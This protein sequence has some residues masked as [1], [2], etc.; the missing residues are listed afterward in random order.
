[1][2]SLRFVLAIASLSLAAA[3][4]A[5]DTPATDHH[6]D[7]LSG[8]KANWQQW[9]ALPVQ[10]GGRY[11][12]LDSLCWE[13]GRL[14]SNRISQPDPDTGVRLDAVGFYL[15]L[16]FD[17]QI[18]EKNQGSQSASGGDRL[19]TYFSTREADK[20]DRQPLIV[21]DS[22]ELRQALGMP[23]DKRFIAPWDLGKAKLDTPRTKESS[24]LDWAE[25]LA[26]A[27]SRKLDPFEKEGLQL[28]NRLWAYVEHRSGRRMAIAPV[29][30]NAKEEWLSVHDLLQTK[31]ERPAIERLK[32]Q[33]LKVQAAYRAGDAEAF[34]AASAALIAD[35]V[36][37]GPTLGEYPVQKFINLEVAYNHWAPFRLAWILSLTACLC[38]LLSLGTGLRG[39]YASACLAGVLSLVA[40]LAGFW[41]RVTISG[42]AP[43]TDMY[44]SVVYVGF[45]TALFAL[46][47][48]WL[49]RKQF[50]LAAGMAVAAVAL[51]LA[52]N[53]PAILDPSLRPLQPVLRSNFWLVTHVMTITL[54]YAAFALALGISDITL[55]Y[56]L[57]RP[58]K[59]ETIAALSLFS[60]RA[61]QVGV[62][63]L[64][65]GIVLGGVW[66]QYSWGRFWGWDPKEVW[67]LIALLG[68][69]A[70]L[71]A[72]F[73]GWVREL[74]LAALSVICFLLVVM[75]WYGV[76]FVLGAGLHSYGFGSGASNTY[77]GL[78][79]LG[80][81]LYMIAAI[82]R[83]PPQAAG[84]AQPGS[85]TVDFA[86]LSPNA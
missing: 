19:R 50:I 61:L 58:Q 15:T 81:L 78:V 73:V 18:N 75:A 7:L 34:N 24:F 71:H 40:M 6:L 72:R 8:G 77:V 5:A 79:L 49:Y 43:V 33:W 16:I 36:D 11:K 60:Y 45:G 56:F 23:A 51:I 20:W 17:W 41:L 80:Q 30:S 10:D 42:R 86:E 38:A 3:G 46:F 67:A 74:G 14:V 59:R 4:F 48:E 82:F 25:V 55:G 26:R 22:L 44:E 21:I 66:A 29:S 53:Y 76:N 12:P 64:A 9:R 69:I 39:F 70:V 62:V 83:A 1:M 35:A 57:F 54:S 37:T 65:A 2:R 13:F 52:D 32:Q 68:Y 85:Q 28:A 47:F 27:D 63:L 84:E 31:S